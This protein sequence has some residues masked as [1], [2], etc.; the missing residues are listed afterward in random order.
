MDLSQE[1]IAWRLEMHDRL[2]E[3]LEYTTKALEVADTPGAV[4]RVE[5][6]QQLLLEIVE[7]NAKS[8][9]LY[10]EGMYLPKGAAR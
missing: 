5:A 7:H 3:A 10:G 6:S 2:V 8:R 4:Y 1:E 9:G